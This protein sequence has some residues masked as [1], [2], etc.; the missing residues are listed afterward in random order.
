[1]EERKK[2]SQNI[3]T[4][5]KVSVEELL[6]QMRDNLPLFSQV[7]FPN[8]INKKYS[9]PDFHKQ[10]YDKFLN[11]GRYVAVAAPRNHS[12]TTLAFVYVMNRVLYRQARHVVL[13]SETLDQAEEQLE[14]IRDECED[15]AT[16]K[17]FFGD[18]TAVWDSE[19]FDDEVKDRTR[20][21]QKVLKLYLGRDKTGTPIYSTIR[22]RGSGQKVRGRK[23]GRFRPD[24]IFLDDIESE[25]T[26]QTPE[27]RIK[28]KHWLSR[29]VIP[30]LD[31]DRG[32]IVIIGTYPHDDCLLK[33]LVDST[34]RKGYKVWNVL[35]FQAGFY[36]K[37]ILWKER[38]TYEDLKDERDKYLARDDLQGY[39]QE[40]ENIT[41]SED[42]IQFTK[43][44]YYESDFLLSPKKHIDITNKNDVNVDK[45]FIVVNTYIGWDLAIG[46]SEGADY[47]AI[48]VIARDSEDNRYVLEYWEKRAA[49]INESVEVVIRFAVKYSVDA[50][51]IETNNFQ[52]LAYQILN[53]RFSQDNLY[54]RIIPI[55]N[56]RNKIA[57]ISRIAP[58]WEDNKFWIKQDMITLRD[59]LQGFPN[60]KHEHILDSIEMA[61]RYSL[62]PSHGTVADVI[63]SE[64]KSYR[65]TKNQTYNWLTR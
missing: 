44:N 26:V 51:K 40:Y 61:D 49:N 14:T 20:I 19:Y 23:V 17:Q 27:R 57:R 25:E 37:N 1:M 43:R 31:K 21:T 7:M 45:K 46:E 41:I 18:V 15:N 12:K 11:G 32:Q 35:E 39:D 30:S 48:T 47:N 64:R 13:I 55:Q 36:T 2:Q 52:I 38:W 5:Q 42:R 29:A 33:S 24:L 65:R 8:H 34:L 9:V 60:A 63:D 59:E 56:Y 28:T 58:A 62:S 10:I 16:I 50:I 22:A 54:F 3:E 6:Y 53:E 4:S